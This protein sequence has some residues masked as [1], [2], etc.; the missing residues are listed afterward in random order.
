MPTFYDGSGRKRCQEPIR[1]QWDF[2][3][4][5]ICESVPDTFS[6]LIGRLKPLG[7]CDIF[8]FSHSS[9]SVR[10]GEPRLPCR[11]GRPSTCAAANAFASFRATIAA[12]WSSTTIRRPSPGSM[13]DARGRVPASG[14]SRR[15]PRRPAGQLGQH[16]GDSG[17]RERS[18][19][20]GRRHSRRSDDRAAVGTGPRAAGHRHP[21]AARSGLVADMC[22]ALSR[23]TGAGDRRPRR[24]GGHRRLAANQQRRCR[25]S[26]PAVRRSSR[27]PRSFTPT[28]PPTACSAARTCRPCAACTKRSD[29]RWSPPAA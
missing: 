3:R 5:V 14:R 22:R 6:C 26:C 11:F 29:C 28:S 18:L 16:P 9:K 17:R 13:V 19:R 23:P 8:C 25:G 20:A 12:K 24:P 21:C 10:P 2:F 4:L 1:T 15:C 27:W 7:L